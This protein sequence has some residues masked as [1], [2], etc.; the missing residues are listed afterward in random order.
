M[1]KFLA[2][3][4]PAALLLGSCSNDDIEVTSTGSITVNVSTQSV[5][6]DFEI[7][8]GFKQN[9]L[10]KGYSIG[11]Y[12]FLYGED[13][14]LAFSDSTYTTTFGSIEMPMKNVSAGKYTLITLEMLVEDEV[15]TGK[16]YQSPN[17]VICGQK[18]LSTIQIANKNY[19]AYWYSAVGLHAQ[20]IQIVTGR[21][22]NIRV[23]PKGIGC[24]VET[25]MTNFDKSDY[26][27]A[28]LYTKDQPKG[29][30][31]S[32]EYT[33]E[34]RFNY[35]Q[36]NESNTWTRRGYSYDSSG[37]PS[38]TGPDI[39]LLEEGTMRYCFGA[40]GLGSDGKLETSFYA[41]P[42]NN[43]YFTFK[44]G[45]TYYGGYNYNGNTV[46]SKSCDAGMFSTLSA[47]E[48]WYEG[49]TLYFG[50]SAATT[51]PKPY[52]NFGANYKT[53]DS[54][55]N[56]TGMVSSSTNTT[57]DAFNAYYI[58][59]AGSVIYQYV[60]DLNRTNLSQTWTAYDSN[61]YTLLSAKYELDEL[62]G[63]VGTYNSEYNAYLYAGSNY[64]GM[65]M[66]VA[67]TQFIQGL[68]MSNAMNAPIKASS[69]SK[70]IKSSDYPARVMKN[71]IPDPTMKKLKSF[72]IKH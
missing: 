15:G 25:Y 49:L 16:K 65:L 4:A 67:G 14:K 42:S 17:W 51:N 30:F 45:A 32:P 63:I 2:L 6:D 72:R 58:N 35:D 8:T 27:L 46:E 18:N 56:S 70:M 57:D 9:F 41:S 60:F 33:G 39:Y 44:D 19:N 48:N 47:Y 28:A 20:N 62:L 53:V 66:H 24:I 71:V 68:F 11:V 64:T 61:S 7:S 10:G 21:N 40:L 23:V 3:L 34:E 5:Y 37:L 13:G 38:F 43:T 54:Y 29:R 36:Y 12:N 55:M 59:S 22:N 52:L 50:N 1:K 26:K 69:I 31:L